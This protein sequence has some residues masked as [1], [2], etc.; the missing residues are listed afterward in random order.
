MFFKTRSG[1][2][3]IDVSLILLKIS[4]QNLF[5]LKNALTVLF[6]VGFFNVQ[7]AFFVSSKQFDIK[8]KAT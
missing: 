2:Q 7:K 3:L 5:K 1:A 8:A 4:N 6:Q